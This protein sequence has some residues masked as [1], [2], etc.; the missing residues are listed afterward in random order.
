MSEASLILRRFGSR[1]RQLHVSEVNSQ[2]QHDRLGVESIF[3]FQKISHMVPDNVPVI[4]ESRVAEAA[5]D[6]EIQNALDA[7]STVRLLASTGD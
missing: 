1:I 6:D 4:L 2:S 3:A 5:I 7:L